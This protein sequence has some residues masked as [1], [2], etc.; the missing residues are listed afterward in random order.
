[1]NASF[2]TFILPV[3]IIVFLMLVLIA[4]AVFFLLIR[5]SKAPSPT[6]SPQVAAHQAGKHAPSRALMT[7]SWPEGSYAVQQLPI[8]IGRESD[9]DIVINDATVSRR[10]ARIYYDNEEE[11]FCIEDLNSDNGMIING[12]PSRRNI[13]LDR[14][15]IRLGETIIKVSGLT[16][17]NPASVVEKEQA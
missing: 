1:M 15:Q 4:V 6:K 16:P 17:R 3:I 8:T 12:R 2:V 13:L 9:N 7:L 11:T 14:Y 5:G 10:H